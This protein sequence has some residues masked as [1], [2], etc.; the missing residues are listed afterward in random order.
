M[1]SPVVMRGVKPRT[2]RAGA[3]SH[4]RALQAEAR[5]VPDPGGPISNYIVVL[6]ARAA[7]N[8]PGV[9]PLEMYVNI[10]ERLI[11]DHR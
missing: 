11:T 5:R 1:S 2:A 8:Q 6:D 3:S 7:A 10:L 9:D 4:K